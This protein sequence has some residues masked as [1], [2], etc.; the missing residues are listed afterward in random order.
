MEEVP[1]VARGTKEKGGDIFMRMSH[2]SVALSVSALALMAAPLAAAQEENTFWIEEITVTAQKRAQSIQDVPIAVSAFN[3]DTLDQI[4]A[5]DVSDL[6]IRTPNFT[7]TQFNI[8]EPQYYIRGVG[9]TSDSA[10]GDPTVAVFIDEVYIGRGG[11]S[12]F[13]FFDLERVEVLRGPQG[14]LFGRNTSG[15]AIS[16]V[17][18]KPSHEAYAKVQATY[19]NYDTIAGKAVINGPLGDTVAAKASVSYRTRDGYSENIITGEDLNDAENFSARLQFLVTP[20]DRLSILVSGDYSDDQTKG[21]ARVPFPVFDDTPTAPLIR[22]LYP[23]DTDIRKSYSGPDTFQDREIWGLMARVDYEADYGTWTSITA[24]R[25]TELSWFEDLSVLPS[26]WILV[27]LDRA[28][29]KAD[30]FSQELRLAS[31]S[32]SKVEWVAGVYYFTES[33]DRSEQFIV[34]F[35]PLPIAGGDVTFFQDAE[36]TSY[37]AFGQV[38]YPVSD[39]FSVTAGVRYTYDEKDIHQIAVDNAQDA[40]LPGIPLFPGQPYDIMADESWDALTGKFGV[41]YKT[42]NGNLLY[43]SISRGFKSGLFSSQGNSPE[44]VAEPLAPE[45]VWNYEVGAKTD[46]LDGR[47]RLNMAAFYLDYTDLQ[48]FLLDAQ[49]RLVTFNVDAEV[50]G[51]EVE[52]VIAP[53][54]WLQLGGNLAYLDT[55][56]KGSAVSGID[57][58]GNK[59]PRSPKWSYNV[60]ASATANVPGGTL[61]GRV[62]FAW[63]DDIFHEATNIDPTFIGS[64]GLL[65]ARIAYT[66][67]ESG[68]ELALWGKNLTD[69]EYQSHV[70]PFLGNGFS[71]F[72][73]PRTYGLTATWRFN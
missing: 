63:Q 39:Q 3:Q 69:E 17:T 29:E 42:E 71:L 1:T 15:G 18:S 12:N 32:G 24:Y 23:E 34:E 58:D 43:A 41:E 49:L 70:I 36:N 59:L 50:K 22:L 2:R 27:N 11:G 6:V 52:T 66:H 7:M 28:D 45:K 62:E 25:E 37:A 31:P 10:G 20:S 53:T 64:Y 5:V 19:G 61:N 30:Q 55:E 47:L 60:F 46:W 67:E 68:V 38:T 14:T 33:V 57:L 44:V 72:G 26:P 40:P 56:I 21:N 51:L 16:V 48:Q 35:A 8:G 54:R 9:S 13:D 73:P 4:Q 65:D